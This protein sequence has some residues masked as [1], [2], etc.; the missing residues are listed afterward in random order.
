VVDGFAHEQIV[1]A[2]ELKFRA[3]KQDVN[4]HWRLDAA[5]A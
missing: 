1:S 3:L 5:F 2:L 4:E